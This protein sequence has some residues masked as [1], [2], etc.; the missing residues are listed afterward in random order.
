VPSYQKSWLQIDTCN[1]CKSSYAGY[2]ESDPR[3]S[4]TA[5]KDRRHKLRHRVERPCRV[6]PAE[7]SLG[8]IAGIATDISRSGL[9]VHI[10]GV[11]AHDLRLKVGETARVLIDLPP[12]VNYE[13]RSLE[14]TA[15]VVR[16]AGQDQ[17][18]PAL[19]FEIDRMKIQD[20]RDRSCRQAGPA[21]DQVQ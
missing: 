19:A 8:E 9:L 17:D 21:D 2:M 10:P 5:S 18:T 6:E 14:C 11:A 20:R 13:P 3:E 4:E 1:S 12:S 16:V 7:A 15:R